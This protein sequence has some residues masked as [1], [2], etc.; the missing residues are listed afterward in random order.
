MLVRAPLCV[1][2]VNRPGQLLRIT[3][4]IYDN[5]LAIDR[6]FVT[7]GKER[8][9]ENEF[10]SILIILCSSILLLNAQEP[11][12]PH[13]EKQRCFMFCCLCSMLLYYSHKDADTMV[14]GKSNVYKN[15]PKMI[16]HVTETLKLTHPTVHK[17]P[18]K[19][20]FICL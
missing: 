1:E 20:I 18:Q 12:K 6:A 16:F 17:T 7:S 5:G 8:E 4:A 11:R 10:S 3:N 9:R 13:A 2:A 15:P 19:I 14:C